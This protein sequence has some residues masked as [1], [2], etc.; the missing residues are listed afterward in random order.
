LVKKYM[1]VN[2]LSSKA[3]ERRETSSRGG[4]LHRDFNTCGKAVAVLNGFGSE[5]SVA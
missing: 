4:F 5:K 1:Q 3:A 2:E